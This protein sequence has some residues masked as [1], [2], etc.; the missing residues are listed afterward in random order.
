MACLFLLPPGTYYR[1]D[2]GTNIKI[3]IEIKQLPPYQVISILYKAHWKNSMPPF[4]GVYRGCNTDNK[5]CLII[6]Q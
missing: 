5:R 1:K 4:E 3:W 6:C 2:I